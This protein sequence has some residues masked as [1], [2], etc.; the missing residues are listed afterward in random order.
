MFEIGKVLADL[1]EERAQLAQAILNLEIL[2]GG[3]APRRGRP[4]MWMKAVPTTRKRGRP[5]GSKNKP[6][7]NLLAKQE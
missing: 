2:A 5:P 6:A 3:R 1:R 7:A 4:P